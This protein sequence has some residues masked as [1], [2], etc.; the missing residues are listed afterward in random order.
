MAFA[1]DKAVESFKSGHR[2]NACLLY[3]SSSDKIL[4][5][6]GDETNRL[7]HNINHCVMNLM[8]EFSK[9]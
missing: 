5:I 9:S 8:R 1:I 7:A 2:F 4:L 6:V 3:E